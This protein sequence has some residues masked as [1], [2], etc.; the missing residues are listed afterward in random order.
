ML[1]WETVEDK[2]YWAM[3]RGLFKGE[4]NNAKNFPI[5]S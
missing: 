2:D 1:P 3:V 5:Q 4:M